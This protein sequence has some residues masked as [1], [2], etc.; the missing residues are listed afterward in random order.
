VLSALGV[1]KKFLQY[2]EPQIKKKWKYDKIGTII[3]QSLASGKTM[4]FK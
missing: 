4:P 1:L 3:Q 2:L